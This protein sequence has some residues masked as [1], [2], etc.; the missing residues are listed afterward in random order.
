MRRTPSTSNRLRRAVAL[1]LAGFL[2]VTQMSC[3]ILMHPERSGHHGGRLAVVSVLLDCCWLLV[4]LVPGV[5]ALGIDFAS[6]GAW[7]VKGEHGHGH[8]HSSAPAGHVAVRVGGNAPQA[9]ELSLRIVDA[10]G[11]D[12]VAPARARVEKGARID[13]LE[14]ALPKTAAPDSQIVL[15]IDGREQGRW[16]APAR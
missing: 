9:C 4:G 10:G 15:A 16:P 12:L 13:P 7:H 5:V 2:G 3:G 14:L 8:D 6:G 11:V 1:V